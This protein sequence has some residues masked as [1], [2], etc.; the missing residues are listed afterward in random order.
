MMRVIIL[1]V[2]LAGYANL[3]AES[4]QAVN[5]GPIHEAFV[6]QESGSLLFEAVPNA[7]PPRIT[8]LIPRQN[9]S[10]VIWIPGYWS[11]SRKYGVFLWVS[12]VWR[13]PPPGMQWIPGQ[14]KNYPQG[15]VWIS[16][17]WSQALPEKMVYLSMPPP[18]PIDQRVPTPPA[19][20]E[21]YFW[22]PGNWQFDSALQQ[23]VWYAG[24]WDL[25]GIHWIYCP[26]HYVWREKGYVFIPGFWDWPLRERGVA[27][28]A[29]YV[30]PESLETLAYEPNNAL[31]SLFI[32][33]HLFPY[34]PNYA[35]LFHFHYFFYY[36]V[37]SAWGAAPPWWNWPT[38]TA[39]SRTDQWALWWWWTHP[40]YPNPTWIDASLVQ[41]IT[42]PPQFVVEMMGKINPPP[43]VT[44][45]GVVGELSLY[46]ALNKVTGLKQPI[47][48]SDP[49]QVVQIQELANPQ[50][51]GALDLDPKGN[52]QPLAQPPE[53]PFLGPLPES[54][55]AAPR[56]VIMPLRPLLTNE[57]SSKEEVIQFKPTQKNTQKRGTSRPSNQHMQSIPQPPPSL[58]Y[59]PPYQGYSINYEYPQAQMQTQ[60]QGRIMGNP[61]PQINPAGP[62]VH[63]VPGDHST[64]PRH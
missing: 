57:S 61:Q 24:R 22:V 14:W 23:Y 59:Q 30:E 39:F 28:P 12:G 49:K 10:E 32:M 58:P 42:P 52:G 20:S 33:E 35:C 13:K 18:D 63:P 16:G 17:F 21:N 27:F 48:P 6:V 56:R 34:W 38:W 8:E 5:D 9:D 55:R 1:L 60:H 26:A 11:W 53:K 51:P 41:V 40:G 25:I 15:W 47:L 4:Y 29:I 37:W 2:V 43:F 45:N 7:P 62:N 31:D 54:L 3:C 64:L 46:R 19:S 50:K 44:P 36:D